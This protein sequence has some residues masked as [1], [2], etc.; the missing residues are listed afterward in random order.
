MYISTYLYIYVSFI[1][2]CFFLFISSFLPFYSIFLSIVLIFPF[3][4]FS[5]LPFSS[6]PTSPKWCVLLS[7]RLSF[8]MSA[9][10]YFSTQTKRNTQHTTRNTQHIAVL[11]WTPNYSRPYLSHE[12]HVFRAV[13]MKR[14]KSLL[15]S[16]A[17]ISLQRILP[18]NMK[19]FNCMTSHIH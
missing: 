14:R 2:G 9:M 10:A 7:L 15:T 5:L 18:P 3:S 8:K 16:W 11:H 12:F 19:G 4:F 1:L 6:I 13:N 17:T